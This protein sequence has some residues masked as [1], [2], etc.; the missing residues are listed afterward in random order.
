[1]RKPKMSEVRA[2]QSLVNQPQELQK[3]IRK[4]GP[5]ARSLR[6][7]EKDFGKEKKLLE[8]SQLHNGERRIGPSSNLKLCAPLTMPHT[9]CGHP[10]S[11]GV[12]SR[13]V[14]YRSMD[15]YQSADHSCEK[16]NKLICANIAISWEEKAN[17]YN[18][19]IILVYQQ[20]HYSPKPNTVP[21]KDIMQVINVKNKTDIRFRSKKHGE[22]QL[23]APSSIFRLLQAKLR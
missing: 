20:S 5:S 10:V 21:E 2:S 15:V 16:V 19:V 12:I 6:K 8:A 17:A 11:L 23:L 4:H 3:D 9:P 7:K 13:L 18:K 1:M 22:H 14:T